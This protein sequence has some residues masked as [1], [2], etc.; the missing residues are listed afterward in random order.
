LSPQRSGIAPLLH[1][2]PYGLVTKAGTWYLVADHSGKPRLFR[3]D[4]LWALSIAEAE[5][6]RAQVV[7]P[8]ALE[9]G[10]RSTRPRGG[11]EQVAAEPLRPARTNGAL[12]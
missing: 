3:T 4:R 2:D 1:G 5:T 7:V 8:D 11:T 9:V 6:R 10:G 12:R